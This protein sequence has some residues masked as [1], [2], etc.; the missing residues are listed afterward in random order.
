MLPREMVR[1]VRRLQFKARRAVEELLGGEYHSVFKGAGIAFEEVRPYQP[2]DDVRS[3]D[4]NVTA[5]MDQPFLKRYIEERERTVILAADVSG[6]QRFGTGRLGKREVL[7]ELAAV[8]A[9]S[10]A[11]NN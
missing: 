10:A 9:F 7:A 3:I 1:H 11:G 6:S 4:W 5:R 2:G 8:L